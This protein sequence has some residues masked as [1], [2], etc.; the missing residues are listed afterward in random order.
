VRC[1]FSH[2]RIVALYMGWNLLVALPVVGWMNRVPH[3]SMSTT[4]VPAITV[5]AVAL[6]AWWFGKRWCLR[7]VRERSA[8]AAA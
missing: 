2:A 3:P 1:G 5:H 4:L 8:H 6:A 7:H